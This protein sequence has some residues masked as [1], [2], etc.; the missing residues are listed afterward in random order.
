[1]NTVS[2]DQPAAARMARES[3]RPFGGGGGGG[4]DGPAPISSASRFSVILVHR[5]GAAMLEETLLTLH[6]ALDPQQ[7][8]VLL[9]DNASS[10]HSLTMIRKHFPLVRVIANP[11]NNGFARANNQA[12]RMARGRYLL[13]LNNDARVSQDILARLE[14]RFMQRPK[15]AIIGCQL[16]GPEGVPQRS[17]RTLPSPWE[18]IGLGWLITHS[19]PPQRAKPTVNMLAAMMEVETIVGACMGVRMN[20]VR[21]AGMLDEDFFFYFEETEWCHRFRQHGWS[22]W[23]ATDLKVI[24]LRGA[25]T[26]PVY[27]GAQLEMF[28]SRLHYYGKVFPPMIAWPLRIYRLLRLVINALICACVTLG[29]GGLLTRHRNRCSIYWYLM[30]WLLLGMPESWGLPDKCV[31]LPPPPDPHHPKV[32]PVQTAG[33]ARPDHESSP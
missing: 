10:D 20:A 14:Q 31:K 29:T 32:P 21:D 1:M 30:I 19:S 3:Q 6:T 13:L 11:C 16:V 28:R 15:A 24:H 26:R 22:I 17:H 4:G 18:E 25:S 23:V 9:V 8:E 27:R 2:S 33:L 5:N 12:I 7:D